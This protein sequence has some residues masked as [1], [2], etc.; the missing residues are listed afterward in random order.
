M[1]SHTTIAGGIKL[2]LG[3]G[4]LRFTRKPNRF[5]NCVGDKLR[6][7]TGGGRGGAKQRFSQAAKAC[8]RLAREWQPSSDL[9]AP[10]P[11]RFL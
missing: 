8:P 5:N 9:P 7:H 10:A 1:A 11:Y 4:G 3:K 6:G 2:T